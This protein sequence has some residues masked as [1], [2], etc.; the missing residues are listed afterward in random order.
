[1]FICVSRTGDKKRERIKMSKLIV[2]GL[3]TCDRK[4]TV[5]AEISKYMSEI[6]PVEEIIAGGSS[7]VDA[8]AKEYAEVM[9]ITYKEYAPD[10]EADLNAASFIRDT[11]MAEHAT[12][13]LVLSN[14]I[15]KESKNLLIEA[16]RNN[17]SI[18]T[19]GVFEGMTLPEIRSTSGYPT[20]F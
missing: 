20:I 14:G 6:G 19:V 8:F 12:H 4:D 3:R 11:R 10:W 15:S 17:L 7:G 13:L 1:V 5:F 16:K 9:E 2:S 18:K